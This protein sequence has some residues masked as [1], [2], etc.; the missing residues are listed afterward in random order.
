MNNSNYAAKEILTL[1]LKKGWVSTECF[2]AGELE[3]EIAAIISNAALSNIS[4]ESQPYT[5]DSAI[6]KTYTF[7]V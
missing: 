6:T 2:S 5:F 7:T 1:L 3:A 4:L